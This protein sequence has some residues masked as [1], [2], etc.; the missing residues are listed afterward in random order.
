MFQVCCA[1]NEYTVRVYPLLAGE[2][3]GN[4]P[5][6]FGEEPDGALEGAAG[7]QAQGGPHRVA[8]HRQ[9]HPLQY[10]L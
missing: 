9:Q 3:V 5:S 10:G 4:P 1:I 6:W 2:G 7:S 8:P